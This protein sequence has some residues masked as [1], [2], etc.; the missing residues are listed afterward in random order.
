MDN[1][2]L[3]IR[4]DD[5]K[6]MARL[7]ELVGRENPTALDTELSIARL[8]YEEALNEGRADFAAH[9]LTVTGKLARDAEVARFRRGELLAKTAI[10]AIA[11]KMVEALTQNIAHKFDGWEQALENVQQQVIQIVSEARN[12]DQ[13]ETRADQV[14]D[15][16]PLEAPEPEGD[17]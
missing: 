5:E 17:E 16:S 11:N 6:R 1:P 3:S 13:L 8:L 12:R 10:I 4:L 9:L 15:V 2:I 14:I 7:R